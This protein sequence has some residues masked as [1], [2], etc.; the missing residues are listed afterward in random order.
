MVCQVAHTAEL[1]LITNRYLRVLSVTASLSILLAE[2]LSKAVAIV[3]STYILRK[4][5]MFLCALFLN[6]LH[7]WL[8]RFAF[9]DSVSLLLISYKQRRWANYATWRSHAGR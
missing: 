7:F 6:R 3:V 9:L 8:V 2:N 5:R 4:H 1:E